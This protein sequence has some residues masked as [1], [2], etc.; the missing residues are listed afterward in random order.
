[1]LSDVAGGVW[2]FLYH[3]A[4]SAVAVPSKENMANRHRCC[5]A[6]TTAAFQ[7]L[8]DDGEG[9]TVIRGVV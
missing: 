7:T 4:A 6:I 3:S 1:M 9:N 2:L 5:G 8:G